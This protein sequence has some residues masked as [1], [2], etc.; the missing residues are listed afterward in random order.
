VHA[1]FR[2]VIGALHA[3]D[4]QLTRLIRIWLANRRIWEALPGAGPA[5]PATCADVTRYLEA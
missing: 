3:T 1:I 2:R 4:D 5:V